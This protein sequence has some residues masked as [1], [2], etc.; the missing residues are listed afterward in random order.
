MVKI[1]LDSQVLIWYGFNK[2]NKISARV[3]NL[4]KDMDNELYFSVASIWELTIK[5]LLN[6]PDFPQDIEKLRIGLLNNDIKE[7]PISPR[8]IKNL[9]DFTHIHK[10]P[11]DRLLLAQAYTENFYF[12]TADSLIL[13]YDFDFIIDVT[14]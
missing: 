3:L 2:P 7:L 1:L 6:K 13:K 14:A 9:H 10:D 12:L 5:S 11:F 4:L 8:Q